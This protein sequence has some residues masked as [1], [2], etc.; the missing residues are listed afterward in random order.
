MHEPIPLE[1]VE[2]LCRSHP[3]HPFSVFEDS[4]GRTPRESVRSGVIA[5]PVA[6]RPIALQMAHTLSRGNPEGSVVRRH[7]PADV[8]IHQSVAYGKLPECTFPEPKD[9]PA[10]RPDPEVFV[11]VFGQGGDARIGQ[12]VFLAI[13]PETRARV[14][15]KAA[16]IVSDPEFAVAGLQNSHGDIVR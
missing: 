2:S 14:S 6:V 11:A 1:P 13:R 15:G 10:E 9:S 7:D 12:S 4:D 5:K 8:V 3:Q 16:A